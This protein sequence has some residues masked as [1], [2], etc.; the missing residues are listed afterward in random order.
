MYKH[1][2]LQKWSFVPTKYPAFL[3]V[4]LCV[5]PLAAVR[6]YWERCVC[7]CERG[8]HVDTLSFY[9]DE[10]RKFFLLLSLKVIHSPWEQHGTWWRTTPTSPTLN[11]TVAQT[12]N[13]SRRTLGENRIAHC[14]APP[15]P[16]CVF[17]LMVAARHQRQCSAYGISKFLAYKKRKEK[18]K[19]I[20]LFS[21]SDASRY[22]AFR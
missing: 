11:R 8:H 21:R 4:R 12:Q 17:P 16:P 5:A 10:C 15:P 2:H 6:D 3:S 7:V 19:Q 1:C 13:E 22:F 9:R 18:K 14:C 20:L